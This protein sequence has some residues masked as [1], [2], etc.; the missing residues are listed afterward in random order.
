MRVTNTGL[1]SSQIYQTQRNMQRMGKLNEQLN[2]GKI[3][4]RASDDK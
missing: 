2:T 4:N 1:T 3:V